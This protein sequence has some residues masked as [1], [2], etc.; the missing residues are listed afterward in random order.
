MYVLREQGG[1][2][3]G[4]VEGV[5]VCLC[6]L[7]CTLRKTAKLYLMKHFNRSGVALCKYAS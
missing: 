1:G 7:V 3:S 2:G 5:R 4:C 6:G